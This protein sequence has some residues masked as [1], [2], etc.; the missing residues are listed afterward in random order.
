MTKQSEFDE[1]RARVLA[2]PAARRAYYVALIGGRISDRWRVLLDTVG[3]RSHAL[4]D[5]RCQH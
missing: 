4:S 3:G 2:D 5:R 1:L